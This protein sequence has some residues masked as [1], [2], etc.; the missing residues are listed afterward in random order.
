MQARHRIPTIFSIYMLDVI[1]CALGCVV[2][3]WQ[4]ANQEAELQT[5]TAHQKAELADERLA[6]Y[7]KM[8]QEFL[9]V[10]DDV[11]KLQTLLSTLGQERDSVARSLELTKAEREEA[12]KLAT[13][14]Q[15]EID[16]GRKALALIEEQLKK[17]ESDLAK[18]LIENKKTI[19]A[20]TSQE[21][22]SA[23]LK[24]KIASAEKDIA[25]L[26]GDIA[27]KQGEIDVAAKKLKEQVVVVQLSEKNARRLQQLFD[28]VRDESKDAQAKLKLTELQL[29]MRDQELE[30]SRGAFKEAIAAKEKTGQQ[31]TAGTKDLLAARARIDEL[32]IER[33]L[34]KDKLL[35][36][37]RELTSAA[38]VIGSLNTEKK[39]LNQRVVDLQLEVDQRFAGIPLTGENV[40]FLID[41]SGS[42]V[43]KDSKTEDPDKW[44]FLCDTLMKLMRSIPSMKRFQVILF[45]DKTSYLFG[46]R[47]YWLRYEGTQTAKATRDALR[48]FEVGG[49]TNMHDAFDEAFRYRKSGLDTIYLFSDGLPNIGEGLPA[50]IAKPTEEQLNFHLGK[51]V[52]TK[53]RDNWNRPLQGKEPVRINSIGFYFESPDV[54]AFLWALTREHRGS[55]VGLR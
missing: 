17:I 31:L 37:S 2:L 12:R 48:K 50:D 16:A 29:K 33:D 52:R 15:D 38:D 47:D 3:L 28:S 42:M 20:L 1:C 32:T 5:A 8:H 35:T 46:S 26:Q 49:G 6:N 55:F 53:L 36:R 7:K 51:Y 18:L 24:E 13:R 25:G 19:A 30:K 43:M 27:L 14:R 4:V 10:S 9:S 54:G 41:V 44:P 40:I 22:I 21:K 23:A 39:T 45:S 11:V 34:L